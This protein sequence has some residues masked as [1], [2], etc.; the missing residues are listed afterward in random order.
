MAGKALLINQG[1]ALMINRLAALLKE[2]HVETAVVEPDIAAIMPEKNSSDIFVLFTADFVY[3]AQD[4]LNFLKDVCLEEEKPLCVVGYDKELA[5]IADSIPRDLVLRQF[6]RPFDVKAVFAE[7]VALLKAEGETSR[8]KHILL[9]DDDTTFLQ[10]MKSW[11]EMSYHVAA[12]RSGMQGISY[13]VEHSVDLI[14][15]DYDM[16]VMSGPQVLEAL[17]SETRSANIPVIFLTGKND[18]DS[19][20][21]VM[22]LKP[23]GYILKSMDR[24]EILSAVDRFFKTKKWENLSQDG[25]A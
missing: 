16:P 9:V 7:I 1:S 14:L 2:A 25:Q 22:H 24:E 17:R 3:D 23:E 10:M 6:P 18:R 20:M 19:V 11:L 15:L 4:F 5:K 21:S 13:I 8:E 12:A